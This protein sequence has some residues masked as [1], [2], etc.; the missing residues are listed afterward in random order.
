[1]SNAREK[2][3]LLQETRGVGFNEAIKAIENKKY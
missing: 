2:N 1:L 3:L